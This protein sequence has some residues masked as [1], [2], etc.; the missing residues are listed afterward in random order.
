MLD[1]LRHMWEGLGYWWDVCQISV[2]GRIA[3][4]LWPLKSGRFGRDVVN[5]VDHR[6]WHQHSVRRSGG[7]VYAL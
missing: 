2:D 3:L 5:V 4:V 1:V 7:D 6:L